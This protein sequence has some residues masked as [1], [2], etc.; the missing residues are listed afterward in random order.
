MSSPKDPSLTK[1]K[2]IDVNCGFLCPS[3]KRPYYIYFEAQ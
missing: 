1:G 2:Y 3:C